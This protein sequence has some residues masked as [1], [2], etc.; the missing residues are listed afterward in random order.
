MLLE[1]LKGAGA[2]KDKEILDL[3]KQLFGAMAAK[4]LADREVQHLMNERDTYKAKYEQLVNF[5]TVE[6]TTIEPRKLSV[7]LL[8]KVIL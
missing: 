6:K 8:G 1:D 3:T 2:K 4:E 7:R 5:K